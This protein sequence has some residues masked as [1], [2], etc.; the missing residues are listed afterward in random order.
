MAWS[1]VPEG[2][3][4]LAV[5]FEEAP[6]TPGEQPRALWV[7]YNIPAT[8]FSLP[9]GIRFSEN[10]LEFPGVVEG[11][12]DFG[13]LGYRGPL[14]KPGRTFRYA[15]RVFALDRVLNLP[16]EATREHLIRSMKGHVL[17]QGQFD[18]TYRRRAA[19]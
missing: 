3:K 5:L 16:R 14:P 4:S 19:V 9:E 18:G 13:R 10:P 12:N 2:T 15:F 8:F 11:K 7:V 1:N 6:A 17:A